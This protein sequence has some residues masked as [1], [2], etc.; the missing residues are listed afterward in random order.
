MECISGMLWGFLGGMLHTQATYSPVL[1]V[2]KLHC[3][4]CRA[5]PQCRPV[6]VS[7]IETSN[8]Q[9]T[10]PS[11]PLAPGRVTSPVPQIMESE[12]ISFI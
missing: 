10:Q 4:H 1:K 7:V 5:C 8:L 11:V 2:L 6:A 12:R 3:R 9:A